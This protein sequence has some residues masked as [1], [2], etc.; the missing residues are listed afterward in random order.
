MPTWKT[1]RRAA[2]RALA[3]TVLTAAVAGTL[4]A[5]AASAVASRARTGTP[6]P[7]HTE[8]LVDGS[9]AEIY[10]LGA[11][12]Y[13]MEIIDRDAVYARLEANQRDAGVDA[14]DM[15]V[16]LTF[17]G[18][19]H[20]WIG[21]GHRGPGGFRLPDDSTAKVTKVG[22]HHYRARIM[23]RGHVVARLEANQRDA[24]MD[25][26]GLFVVLTFDGEISASLT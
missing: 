21:G 17:D 20:S 23:D 22:P 1:P 26:N 14:N 4:L 7:V 12:H 13:R 3:G 24:G 6:A 25:G 18:Q 9:T 5:P 11:H 15:F 19:V 2:L 10:K 16:V 8:K